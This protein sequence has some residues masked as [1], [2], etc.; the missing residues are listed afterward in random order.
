[1]VMIVVA[2]HMPGALVLVHLPTR[3]HNTQPCHPPIPR[4]PTCIRRRRDEEL[5]LS[6]PVSAFAQDPISRVCR[7]VTVTPG[8]RNTPAKRPLRHAPL[9]IPT[10]V[11]PAD[12]RAVLFAMVAGGVHLRLKLTASYSFPSL[13]G[14]GHFQRDRT[15]APV[16]RAYLSKTNSLLLCVDSRTNPSIIAQLNQSFANSI[17][18][19]LPR[20]VLRPHDIIVDDVNYLKTKTLQVFRVVCGQHHY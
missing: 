18:S 11:A 6:P 19:V 13:L 14:S 1:M 20:V 15:V 10:N 9:A 17:S 5:L 8:E 4:P 12:A 7:T 16:A 2:L 3:P